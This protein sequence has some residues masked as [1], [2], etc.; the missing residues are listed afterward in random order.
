[1]SEIERIRQEL[2]TQRTRATSCPSCGKI[3]DAATPIQGQH[4]TPGSLILCLSCGAW[5]VFTEALDL[6]I[7]APEE[8]AALD[9]A[10]QQ[11]LAYMDRRWRRL[12]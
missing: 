5:S 1:M 3:A 12:S 4:V 7:L 10:D 6:R 8:R 9:P 2:G 11:L